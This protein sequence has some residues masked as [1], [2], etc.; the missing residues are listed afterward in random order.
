MEYP[1]FLNKFHVGFQIINKAVKAT[2]HYLDGV[3]LLCS[4]PQTSFIQYIFKVNAFKQIKPKFKI[5]SYTYNKFQW[6]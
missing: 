6:C 2:N 5:Q 3:Y 1:Y 4:K